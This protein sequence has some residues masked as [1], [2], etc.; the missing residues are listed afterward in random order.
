MKKVI[1]TTLLLFL[2]SLSF[3]D[4]YITRGPNSGEIY[5][6]GYTYTGEGLF[7][8]TDFG[9]TAVCM[10]STIY[11][12]MRITAD[13]TPGVVY[14][15]TMTEGLYISYDYGNQGTWQFRNSGVYLLIS[16]GV[17]I[18]N[19]YNSI[20]SHSENYGFDFIQ[21]SYNGFFGNTM[22]CE[23]DNQVS[24]V[25]VIT[26][27][28]SVLDTM[29]LLISTDNFENL[30]IQNKLYMEGW[31]VVKLS[32]GAEE[33]ELFL[34]SRQNYQ[35]LYSNDFGISWSV[36][37]GFNQAYTFDDIVGGR[38]PGEVYV[39]FRYVNMSWQN[40]HNYILYST[41]YGV[42]FELFH[43]FNKGMEPL[44][45]NFSAKSVENSSGIIDIK[46]IDS[47]YYVTGD[48]PLEVHFYNY[49]IGDIISV[50]WDF[51]NDGII[52][53]YE[54]NPVHTYADTGWY[55]VNLT[56]YD[57]YDTNSFFRENYIYVYELTGTNKNVF[58]KKA[59][60]SCYPNLFK[61]ETTIFY[62]VPHS[63]NISFNI[64][65]ATGRLIHSEH[66]GNTTEGN[67][68]CILSMPKATPGI[69]YVILEVNGNP[70]SIKK[71]VVN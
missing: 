8:S 61:K 63:S 7:Y 60:F 23:I 47:I 46:T 57:D 29:Y 39:L 4:R 32:R 65:D 48:L 21:H 56:V 38:N 66:S 54:T 53:S 71:V 30:S 15:V 33:G 64:Y 16:S 19:I 9:M 13:K 20:A 42:T 25:Y 27:V 69:Y 70:V 2:V 26:D 18:G 36:I 6:L 35:L 44:I 43:P 45:S 5:F 40:A 59:S 49:S 67:H 62:N 11:D 37:N 14:Y 1:F 34:F 50:E 55:S 41:D 68:Q 51:D 12:A 17:S 3:P 28:T 52:D 31:Y 24:T 10:D 22:D 58:P